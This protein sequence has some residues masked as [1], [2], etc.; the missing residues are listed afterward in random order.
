[1]HDGGHERV[2]GPRVPHFYTLVPPIMDPL[3]GKIDILYCTV[4]CSNSAYL[5]GH[6]LVG[7][8]SLHI[9]TVVYSDKGYGMR[10]IYTVVVG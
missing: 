8:H 10:L 4:K 7:V 3:V 5:L 6:A 9:C 2:S 1:M